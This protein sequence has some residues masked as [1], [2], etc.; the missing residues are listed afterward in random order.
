M[1]TWVLLI[2]DLYQFKRDNPIESYDV[3][4]VSSEFPI[5]MTFFVNWTRV[6][7][8]TTFKRLQNVENRH[9]SHHFSLIWRKKLYG[10]VEEMKE[11]SEKVMHLLVSASK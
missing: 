8:L 11:M 10:S 7:S 5:L 3:E 2:D 1:E 6:Q 4:K 9:F